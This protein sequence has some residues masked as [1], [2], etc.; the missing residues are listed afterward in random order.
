MKPSQ[1]RPIF[2][3][4]PGQPHLKRF[5]GFEGDPGTKAPPRPVMQIPR[6][7]TGL[8]G[9]GGS[10]STERGGTGFPTLLGTPGPGMVYDESEIWGTN[11]PG[12]SV[13]TPPVDP[14]YAIPLPPPGPEQMDTGLSIPFGISIVKWR[15]PTTFQSVPI[16]P[17]TPGNV[18]VLGLNMQR[19]ALVIQNNSTATA[20]DVAPN[21]YLGFNAQPQVGLALTLAPGAGILFDIIT[22]RDSIYVVIA[23]GAGA[24]QIVQGAVVQGT[25]API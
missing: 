9:L 1:R 2:Q 20:P 16:L 8:G 10:N 12:G 15:N 6:R 7:F 3:E 18:P 25:Y 24:S 14:S 23:G 21:F 4:V 22:P 5:V 19:N 11:G 17:T 13:M